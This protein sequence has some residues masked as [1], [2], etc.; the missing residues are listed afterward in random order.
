MYIIIMTKKITNSLGHYSA[1][2]CR[3]QL[4]QLQKLEYTNNRGK[5]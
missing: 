2:M 3:T 1:A 4:D 5:G